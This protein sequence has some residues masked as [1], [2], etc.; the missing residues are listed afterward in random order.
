[1]TADV[2][3][4]AATVAAPGAAEA[5]LWFAAH[6]AHGALVGQWIRSNVDYVVAV[7]PF[8]TAEEQAALTRTLPG[9]AAVLWVVIHAARPA[10][11]PATPTAHWPYSASPNDFAGTLA[12]GALLRSLR[13]RGPA[14]VGE[15]RYAEALRGSRAPRMRPR[16]KMNSSAGS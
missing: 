9:G 15:R 7:G 12:S 5:G 4:I 13:R 2:D 11:T 14:T 16:P 1:V 8:F 6:E 3:D 10:T